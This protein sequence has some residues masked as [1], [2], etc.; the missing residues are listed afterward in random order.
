MTRCPSLFR[1][2]TSQTTSRAP[3]SF[4]LFAHPPHPG[5]L[6]GPQNPSESPRWT[7]AVAF[8]ETIRPQPTACEAFPSLPTQLTLG[9]P[10]FSQI[11]AGR[12]F[13]PSPK[14]L[15]ILSHIT[16]I[17]D[18]NHTV[19]WSGDTWRKQLVMTL[20]MKTERV[21]VRRG[22]TPFKLGLMKK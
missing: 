13:A 8:S 11:V 7:L 3:T 2:L 4:F 14:P 17:K 1:S 20:A 10:R 15:C 18:E 6:L 22:R 12:R 16:T 9:P 5:L 21:R 19:L